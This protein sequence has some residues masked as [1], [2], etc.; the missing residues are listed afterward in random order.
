MKA[1]SA[2][3]IVGLGTGACLLA[4]WAA[5]Y[6]K[7]NAISDAFCYVPQPPDIQCPDDSTI[8][9]SLCRI[10]LQPSAY[11]VSFPQNSSYVLHILIHIL[12]TTHVFGA[13]FIVS[14]L[15]AWRL[16]FRLM[17]VLMS[18]VLWLWMKI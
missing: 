10:R 6:P 14:G 12:H 7:F 1:Y 15:Q 18:I 9:A 11:I 2:A 5:E 17:T 13:L 4:T 8:C 16:P 3:T